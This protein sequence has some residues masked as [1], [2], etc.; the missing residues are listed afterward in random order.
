M[1]GATALIVGVT[2]LEA[3]QENIQYPLETAPRLENYL[4]QMTRRSAA[5]LWQMTQRAFSTRC[6]SMCSARE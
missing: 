3:F 2:I 1:F 5:A 4:K 6:M